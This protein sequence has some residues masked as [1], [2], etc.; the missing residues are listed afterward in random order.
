VRTTFH[1]VDDALFHGIAV[2]AGGCV[3]PVAALAFTDLVD[4]DGTLDSGVFC[5]LAKWF[6]DGL[7]QDG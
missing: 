7:A 3:E 2:F 4:G 5:N 1:R 6:F